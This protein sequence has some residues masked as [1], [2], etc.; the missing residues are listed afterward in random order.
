MEVLAEVHSM[1]ARNYQKPEMDGV[2][3]MW[4]DIGKLQADDTIYPFYNDGKLGYGTILTPSLG[5]Y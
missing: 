2:Y 3:I 5:G 4:E 1:I